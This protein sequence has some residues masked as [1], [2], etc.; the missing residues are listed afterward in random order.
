MAT[1]NYPAFREAVEAA[2]AVGDT[3][4]RDIIEHWDLRE[5]RIPSAP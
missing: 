3:V 2:E 5:T 4:V 1:G